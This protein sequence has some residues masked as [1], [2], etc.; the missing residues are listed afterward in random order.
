MNECKSPAETM[1]DLLDRQIALSR[2]VAGSLA[3]IAR[4]MLGRM[5][6]GRGSLLPASGCAIPEPCWMPRDLGERACR[7][8]AGGE[9][10]I[11]FRITN[12][13]FRSR[14]FA[15]AATGP[16]AARVRVEPASLT[17]GPKERGVVT[18]HFDT[19]QAEGEKD[20]A[21]TSHEALIWVLG[22]N[23]H[24]LRWTIAIGPRGAGCC[25]RVLVEDQ[26][27]YIHHWY[28]HFY[29]ARPCLG[30]AGDRDQPGPVG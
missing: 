26:P 3:G 25:D 28:D 22:C 12:A 24:Y 8:Q 7:V 30:Q 1:C 2:D 4:D 6:A 21:T 10:R 29:C 20:C 18:V 9:A 17:L 11:E 16:D 19:G 23:R 15:V 27:D 5:G 14:S 13:D